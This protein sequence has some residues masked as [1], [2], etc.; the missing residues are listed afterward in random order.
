MKTSL[1]HLVATFLRLFSSLLTEI[2]ESGKEENDQMSSQQVKFLLKN[3][4]GF[5]ALIKLR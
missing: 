2:A 1:M 5:A 3:E 4:A